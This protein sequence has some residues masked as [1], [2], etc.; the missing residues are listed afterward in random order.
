METVLRGYTDSDSGD[1]SGYVAT[2][3][4]LSERMADAE[5]WSAEKEV[6]AKHNRRL[7]E[8]AMRDELTGIANRRAFNLILE[9][10][11]SRHSR[12]KTPL[13][14]LI[15]DVDFFKKYNDALGHPA[16]DRCLRQL[17]QTLE[18]RVRRLNDR[19]ARIGGEEFAAILPETDEI[20]ARTVGDDLLDA[21]RALEIEHPESPFGRVT[22]SIGVVTMRP[23]HGV[24][25]AMAMQLADRALYESKR[26]GRNCLTVAKV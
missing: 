23:P 26:A 19:V 21:V 15:I 18:S 7:S 22:V 11:F 17:A 6:L 10:E 20:G 4:D 8:L 1:I 13:T 12:S 16:G 2:V 3:R 25:S 9:G 5:A 14:L 24:G